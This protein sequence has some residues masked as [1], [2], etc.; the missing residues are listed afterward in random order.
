MPEQELDFSHPVMMF[1]QMMMN[2]MQYQDPAKKNTLIAEAEGGNEWAQAIINLIVDRG[3]LLNAIN[4]MHTTLAALW[5]TFSLVDADGV[6][7]YGDNETLEALFWYM[8]SMDA[9][10]ETNEVKRR[11]ADDFMEPVYKTVVIEEQTDATDGE[12]EI[13]Q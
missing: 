11:T 8:S 10:T 12:S 5:E 4:T 2:D 7:I 3:R 13:L 6:R 9:L 1:A